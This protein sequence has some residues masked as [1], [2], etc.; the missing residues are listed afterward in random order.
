MAK[1]DDF[2]ATLSDDEVQ[3][4][5]N[6]QE[7]LAEAQAKFA[8]PQEPSTVAKAAQ[9]GVQAATLPFKHLKEIGSTVDDLGERTLR[10]VG[11]TTGLAAAGVPL[12]EAL[13]TGGRTFLDPTTIPETTSAKQNLAGLAGGELFSLARPLN[14]A[15][16][17]LGGK[18]TPTVRS[19]TAPKATL[20]KAGKAIDVAEKSAGIRFRPTG[21]LNKGQRQTFLE[22]AA[23]IN[24]KRMN[25][26][27]LR[28][29][30][31]SVKQIKIDASKVK[32]TQK[33]AGQLENKLLK[34]LNI[35]VPARAGP[36][37]LFGRAQDTI[38]LLGKGRKIATRAA[39]STGVT[40]FAVNQLRK[41]F[42]G[43]E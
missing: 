9:L 21:E 14:L 24:P 35:R 33:F 8:V 10:G 43:G 15:G 41:L 25:L 1:L 32:E 23:N 34:E 7:L 36:A 2:I 39:V 13:K 19:V 22:E 16:A 29:T 42:R 12:G 38:D 40:G 6:D 3:L 30:I 18:A 26:Q 11:T 4:L 20:A 27:D 37:Q 31:Q 28:D 5:L 17:F